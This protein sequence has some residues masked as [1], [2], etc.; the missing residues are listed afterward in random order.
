M[1]GLWHSAKAKILRNIL[2]AECMCISCFCIY[3]PACMHIEAEKSAVS[4]K[5]MKFSHII[6]IWVNDEA[7]TD[8]RASKLYYCAKLPFKFTRKPLLLWATPLTVVGRVSCTGTMEVHKSPGST[9][10][11]S[12]QT[13]ARPC[14]TRRP[15]VPGMGMTWLQSEEREGVQLLQEARQGHSNPH[16]KPPKP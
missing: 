10:A 8:A 9:D 1:V 3:L 14:V 4:H 2:Q 7:S 16:P 5:R 11:S 15:A 6:S 12:W 13:S